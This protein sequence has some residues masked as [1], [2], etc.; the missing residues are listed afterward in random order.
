MVTLASM[1]ILLAGAI[2]VG[3]D[4]VEKRVFVLPHGLEA[5]GKSIDLPAP[6]GQSGADQKSYAAQTVWL[7]SVRRRIE[8]L[9]AHEAQ[10]PRDMAN[11]QAS[12][13]RQHGEVVIIKEW[14]PLRA[15]FE[16]EG[17]QFES[18]SGVLKTRHDIAMNAIRNLKG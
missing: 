9:V 16:R 12:E 17:R 8:P 5:V 11:G 3:Q 14:G 13:K 10:A 15:A 2:T 4:P 18:L 1:L 6:D 7:R